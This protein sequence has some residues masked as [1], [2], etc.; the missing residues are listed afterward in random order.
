MDNFSE[1]SQWFADPD[2]LCFKKYVST[3][4]MTRRRR[5]LGTDACTSV[6]RKK[7]LARRKAPLKFHIQKSA[8]MRAPETYTQKFSNT[9]TQT[10]RVCA[11]TSVIYRKLRLYY[12]CLFFFSFS[13]L[14]KKWMCAC[15]VCLP[16][17]S[18]I[19]HTWRIVFVVC[20]NTGLLRRAR[21]ARVSVRA[22][23]LRGAFIISLYSEDYDDYKGNKLSSK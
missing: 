17:V 2:A 3:H 16:Q 4:T 1:N 14:L 8:F 15:T 12:I 23:L 7:V 21:W 9:R 18:T 6:T 22:L 19:R 10:H 13:F 5:A 20:K 11:R